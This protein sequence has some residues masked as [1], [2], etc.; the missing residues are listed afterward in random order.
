LL[1]GTEAPNGSVR[2]DVA[3]DQV[4]GA[5]RGGAWGGVEVGT[6]SPRRCLR[7]AEA[8]RAPGDRRST[9]VDGLRGVGHRDALLGRCRSMAPVNA[10]RLRLA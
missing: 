9:P 3:A 4:D 2:A 6:D 8:G 7:R 10:R 1:V 5:E